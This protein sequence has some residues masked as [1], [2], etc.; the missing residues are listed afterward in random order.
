MRKKKQIGAGFFSNIFGGIKKFAT[1]LFSGSKEKIKQV[2]TKAITHAKNAG[3]EAL[4]TGD[5]KG[6]AKKA[7]NTVKKEA[8]NMA[9]E[10]MARI[11]KEGKAKA[12]EFLKSK[13]QEALAKIRGTA[14]EAVGSGFLKK[15]FA[16]TRKHIHGHLDKLHKT[17]RGH[18]KTA[19]EHIKKEG[20][21]G[22][23]AMK[24]R[25]HAVLHDVHKNGLKAL[26]GHLKSIKQDVHAAV[27]A[28]IASKAC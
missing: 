13:H 18:V 26:P 10:E 5:I 19:Y 17:G 15:H 6:A 7:F 24:K 9:K 20:K 21:A 2:A 27:N 25:A 14:C 16:R 8:T 4:K 23:P 28:K 3:A 11:T 12:H 22:I 1:N